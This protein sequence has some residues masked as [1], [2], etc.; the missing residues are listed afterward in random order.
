MKSISIKTDDDTFNKL[1]LITFKAST[2]QKQKVYMKDVIL[3]SINNFVFKKYADYLTVDEE[4]Q[5]ET[6]VTRGKKTKK[7]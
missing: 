1:Q 6:K 4:I 3:E 2:D 5:P 7:V